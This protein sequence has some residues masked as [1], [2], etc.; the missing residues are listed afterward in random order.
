[1]QPDTNFWVMAYEHT[2]PALRWL[3]GVLTF[4]YVYIAKAR[5][6]KQQDRIEALERAQRNYP[7]KDDI[8][9]VRTRMDN[10]FV[11]VH[12]KIDRILFIML[13][14]RRNEKP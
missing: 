8:K 13:E 3:L 4:G 2:P 5:W 7:N 14:D 6:Q 1:M 12:K 10:G 11:A 9:E